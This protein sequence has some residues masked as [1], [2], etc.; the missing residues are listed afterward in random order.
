MIGSGLA[1]EWAAPRTAKPAAPAAASKF[2]AY[3]LGGALLLLLLLAI[4]LAVPQP[5][6]RC[7]AA[8]IAAADS[9]KTL[10]TIDYYNG[11]P[12]PAV[13]TR[14]GL[15]TGTLTTTTID[16]LGWNGQ[17]FTWIDD[18][19]EAIACNGLV[20]SDVCV[21]LR[22]KIQA[23]NRLLGA[24]DQGVSAAPALFQGLS[25]LMLALAFL[26]TCA[27]LAA[28][29]K[30]CR[31]GGIVEDGGASAMP[32]GLIVLSFFLLLPTLLPSMYAVAPRAAALDAVLINTFLQRT[33]SLGG[34]WFGGGQTTNGLTAVLRQP[35]PT[36]QLLGAAGDCFNDS[37]LLLRAVALGVVCLC[38]VAAV[39]TRSALLAA[40]AAGRDKAARGGAVEMS[41]AN[42]LGP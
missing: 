4:G 15:V 22:P 12:P 42:P 9:A 32:L 10:L 30:V 24:F 17:P 25:L 5:T 11:P 29:A 21:A 2:P 19:E 28:V 20:T 8:T 7:S 40:M 33:I 14:V 26:V 34:L 36:V 35:Q 27:Q 3:V 41:T 39:L 13:S 1:R 38:A 23:A 37:A 16:S 31:L 18:T 6:A